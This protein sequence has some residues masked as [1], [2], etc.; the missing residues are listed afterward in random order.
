MMESILTEKQQKKLD[1]EKQID[2]VKERIKK[3]EIEYSDL[4]KELQ[5]YMDELEE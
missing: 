5:G 2:D 1:L 3:N 4:E